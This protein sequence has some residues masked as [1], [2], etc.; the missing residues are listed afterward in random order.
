MDV[1]DIYPINPELFVRDP[2][3][4]ADKREPDLFDDYLADMLLNENRITQNNQQPPRAKVRLT[5]PL[6]GPRVVAAPAAHAPLPPVIPEIERRNS[7][8]TDTSTN[9]SLPQVHHKVT[10]KLTIPHAYHLMKKCQ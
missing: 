9:T 8:P 6:A 4:K 5:V 1:E 2:S 3:R 10:M 7:V